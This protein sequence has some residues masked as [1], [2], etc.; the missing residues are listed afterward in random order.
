MNIFLVS[1]LA[2]SYLV[3]LSSLLFSSRWARCLYE[4]V[5]GVRAWSK[6]VGIVSME[7]REE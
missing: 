5:R 7:G 3:L 4:Y 2:L 6:Y 1:R